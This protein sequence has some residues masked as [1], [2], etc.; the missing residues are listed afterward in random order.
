ML[1]WSKTSS[2]GVTVLH[3]CKVEEPASSFEIY[4]AALG[5]EVQNLS[6]N[7]ISF[8][9]DLL[10]KNRDFICRLMSSYERVERMLLCLIC[11]INTV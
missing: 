9:N 5:A 10:K 3:C 8:N 6:S 7:R 2:L 4:R 1:R 11:Q